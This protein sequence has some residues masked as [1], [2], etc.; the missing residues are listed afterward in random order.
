MA[1]LKITTWNIKHFRRLLPTPS[2]AS[3]RARYRAVA[4]EIRDID[5]DILCIVEGPGDLTALRAF[6]EAPEGLDGD[7]A[8]A[9][10]AGTEEALAANPGNPRSALAELY[11]M[12]GNVLTGNQWIWFLVR[13]DLAAEAGA[14]VQP[15][16]T[17]RA[18]TGRR[19]WPVHYWGRHQ[20]ETHG[21][22]RHPQV[23]VLELAGRR[24]ELIGVHMKSKI[25][26]ERVRDDA[27]NLRPEFVQDA[28]EARIKLATEAYDVRAYIDARY[29]QEPEPA[30]FVLGDLNDGPGRAYF[31]R[32]YLFF[33]LVSNVQGDMFFADRF[34][35][36]GLFDFP[37]RLRW[38]ARFDDDVE[39]QRPPERLLDHILF[40]QP[41]VR[42]EAGPRIAAGA[43]KVEHGAHERANAGL[44]GATSDHRPVSLTLSL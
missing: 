32:R 19:R 36:H 7:Y 24:V 21:H 26:F 10:I 17:W 23:L 40:T 8:V 43:G 37:G 15:P 39:P 13:K 20:E 44:D 12:R 11:A 35:N 6:A 2:S 3:E 25:N 14:H 16:R 38:S 5:P 29:A 33:D 42:A 1:E 22:W 41:L 34:L 18:W 31:E 9:T 30:I 4:A 28:L 27:G